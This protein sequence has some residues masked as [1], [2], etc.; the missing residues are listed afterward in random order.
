MCVCVNLLFYFMDLTQHLKLFLIFY[1]FFNHF[2]YCLLISTMCLFLLLINL[3][4]VHQFPPI[5]VYVIFP[6]PHIHAPSSPLQI[7][8]NYP[9]FCLSWLRKSKSKYEKIYQ[10]IIV[11]FCVDSIFF[12]LIINISNRQ[13]APKISLNNN[14]SS[15]RAI[16][17]AHYHQRQHNLI[18]ETRKLRIHRKMRLNHSMNSTHL[19]RN[20]QGWDKHIE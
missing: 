14:S 19:R 11:F 5:C 15:C 17:S 12:F 6:F 20:I 4:Q 9:Y 7:N 10:K 18:I 16:I 8:I 13:W 1:V 3:K 2:P